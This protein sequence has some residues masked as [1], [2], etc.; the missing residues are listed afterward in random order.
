VEEDKSRIFAFVSFVA[1]WTVTRKRFLNRE[2]G[3]KI[4][5]ISF[6]LPPNYQ[7]FALTEMF[8]GSRAMYIS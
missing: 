6:I 1:F 7:A 2:G 5:N 4:Q 8:N 3:Q